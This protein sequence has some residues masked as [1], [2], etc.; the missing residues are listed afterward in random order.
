MSSLNTLKKL[1]I[2]RASQATSLGF[3]NKDVTRL[4]EAG[5]LLKLDRGVYQHCEFHL[6]ASDHDFAVAATRFGPSAV[7]GGV[8][9]LFHYNLTETIPSRVWII[10][11]SDKKTTDRR[12]RFL[13]TKASL[14]I[15]VEKKRRYK[16][17]T[18]ERALV[19]AFYYSSKIGLDLAMRAIATALKQKQT[20]LRRVTA[21]A[22]KLD[23]DAAI[24]RH[25]DAM[26][27]F[28]EIA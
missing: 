12:Y 9:A 25:W 14:T 3:T 18:F 21:M 5:K 24:N 7:I 22:K 11:P 26:V 6:D 8:S 2:F 1:G 28:Q 19:E 20:T 23:M 10:T 27:G 17:V 4:V 13:R 16:I 15:G